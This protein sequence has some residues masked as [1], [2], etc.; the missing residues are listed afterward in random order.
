MVFAPLVQTI[1][2]AAAAPALILIGALMIGAIAE[3]DWDDPGVAIPAFLTVIVTPLS[4][5]IANGLAFGIISYAGLRLLRGQARPSDWL[6]FL[7]AAMFIARF[8]YLAQA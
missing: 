5:S 3:I 8:I 6:L 4:Y 7:L 1:P 2:T